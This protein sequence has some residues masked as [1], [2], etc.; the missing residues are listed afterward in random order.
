M[1]RSTINTLPP[2]IR[3]WLSERLIQTGFQGYE[4]I[5]EEL[6]G[7]GYK[8]SRMAVWRW[9]SKLEKEVRA[10]QVRHLAEMS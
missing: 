10:A 2:E 8:R 5:T 6:A 3:K 9:G 1:A 7:K 4:R